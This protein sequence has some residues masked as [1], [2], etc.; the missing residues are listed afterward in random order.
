MNKLDTRTF[1]AIVSLLVL[2]GAALAQTM[3]DATQRQDGPAQSTRPAISLTQA[4]EAASGAIGGNVTDA[5]LSDE[6]GQ[7]A[8]EIELAQADGTVRTV[9]VDGQTG[10]IDQT[11]AMDDR[12]E[13]SGDR[14]GADDHGDDRSNDGEGT[15]N[16]N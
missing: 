4:I 3:P 12:Q 1:A 13:P 10:A 5:G 9:L 11:S 16:A 15:E 7:V 2:P 6:A 8:W 14:D